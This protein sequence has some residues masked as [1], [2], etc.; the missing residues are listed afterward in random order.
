MKIAIIEDQTMF[1]GL[2]LD[3]FE[4][5]FKPTMLLQASDGATALKIIDEHRP[6]LI[7]LDLELPDTDGLD[8]LPKLR[9]LVPSSKIIA[10]SC[11]T[12]EVTVHRVI[13]SQID[14]FVDKNGQPMGILK[15]A[16]A[17][18][19]DGRRYY[20]PVI[21]EVW[22]RLRDE[23]AAFNK[24]LSPREQEILALI[25]HGYTNTEIAEQVGLKAITVQTHRCNIMARLGLHTTSHL[26]RYANEKGFTRLRNGPSEE[27]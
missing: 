8:L 1:R 2:L 9:E 18:V 12:D 21:K 4:A 14:G 22:H 27:Q 24:L 25:G 3:A 17:T 15:E 5:A 6:E 19:L 26:M 7:L 10:L 13:R 11:H 23:P 16:V 20:S